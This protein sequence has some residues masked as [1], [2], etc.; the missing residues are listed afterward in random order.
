MKTQL[1]SY[2]ILLFFV[3]YMG[4]SAIYAQDTES[5][6]LKY[7]VLLLQHESEIDQTTAF[8]LLRLH[9]STNSS[10]FYG[11]QLTQKKQSE[12][13]EY[14]SQW[15]VHKS[16]GIDLEQLLTMRSK[17]NAI[18]FNDSLTEYS[19][20]EAALIGPLVGTYVQKKAKVDKD[21]HTEPDIFF[22]DGVVRDYAKIEV[23]ASP[24]GIDD[25]GNPTYAPKD[26]DAFG[27]PIW[28]TELV[29]NGPMLSNALEF[30]DEI[31]I[32]KHGEIIKE[33]HVL[34]FNTPRKE[35][36]QMSLPFF[37]DHQPKAKKLFLE[38][39]CY[40]VLFN[41]PDNWFHDKDCEEQFRDVYYDQYRNLLSTLINN[42]KA[43]KYKLYQLRSE[44]LLSDE[45]VAEEYEE[46][47]KKNPEP[48]AY[49]SLA[50][51]GFFERCETF[52][53]Y[54]EPIGVDAYGNP[55]YNPGDLD[56]YGNPKTKEVKDCNVFFDTDIHGLR[57][58]EDW[59]IHEKT[60][61][62]V[63]KVK[64]FIFIRKVK[65]SQGELTG[66][67]TDNFGQRVFIRFD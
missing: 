31:S 2:L 28:K 67:I 48:M 58:L 37:V 38:N 36:A 9:P 34:K 26:L 64:G 27:N 35:S 18:T 30:V 20:S 1:Y 42:M 60:G 10:Y 52:E 53:V 54:V 56:A 25:Y 7:P 16:V 41:A 45:K 21:Y 49:D 65:D 14:L 22:K 19:I 4:N 47:F 17:P 11:A 15:I 61:A 33:T 12:L 40:D 46:I 55:T 39:V 24:T 63:K 66:S 50:S 62:L 8:Q 29:D 5:V 32:D 57:F 13:T 43:G 3:G 51:H 59:Y 23:P 6:F 44:T